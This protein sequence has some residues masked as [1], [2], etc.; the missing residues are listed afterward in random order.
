MSTP[1]VLNSY[2]D[3][4]FHFILP[5]LLFLDNEGLCVQVTHGLA[6]LPINPG[7]GCIEHG[8]RFRAQRFNLILPE[9]GV[10]KRRLPGVYPAKFFPMNNQVVGSDSF[11]VIQEKILQGPLYR[12]EV[13]LNPII[14]KGDVA[15][16]ADYLGSLSP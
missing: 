15:V 1:I 16:C 12:I 7:N 9:F 14:L 8:F 4:T 11:W 3:N 6:E 10:G 13:N 2:N 5:S